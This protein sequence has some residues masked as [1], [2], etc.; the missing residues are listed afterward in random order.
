MRPA[1]VSMNASQHS[2]CSVKGGRKRG[3]ICLPVGKGDCLFC[4]LRRPQEIGRCE[5]SVWPCGEAGL[6]LGMK[7]FPSRRH[8]SYQAIR[9]A[10]LNASNGCEHLPTSMTP[11]AAVAD[12]QSGHEVK[13]TVREEAADTNGI[14]CP[15]SVMLDRSL[16]VLAWLGIGL[17]W[18][19]PAAREGKDLSG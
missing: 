15:W 14:G 11:C 19:G 13:A 9:I 16:F 12:H 2:L 6:G 7:L 3:F 4:M 17:A 10:I 8:A 5:V 18:E 1:D